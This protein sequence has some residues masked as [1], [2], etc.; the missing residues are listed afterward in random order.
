MVSSVDSIC[1]KEAA[2][3]RRRGHREERCLWGTCGWWDPDSRKTQLQKWAWPVEESWSLLTESQLFW[4]EAESRLGW[5]G[6][7]KG[8]QASKNSRGQVQVTRLVETLADVYWAPS[9]GR[10]GHKAQTGLCPRIPQQPSDRTSKGRVELKS[11]HPG[12]VPE[13]PGGPAAWQQAV[14]KQ[15]GWR[16]GAIREG[17][18]QAWLCWLEPTR[19]LAVHSSRK[20]N[21]GR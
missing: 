7:R 20:Q 2:E 18:R 9:L 16:L 8:R 11:T 5:R 21:P 3:V 13:A 12:V 6:T 19:I 10:K 17:E 14:C 15:A 1:L 4:G